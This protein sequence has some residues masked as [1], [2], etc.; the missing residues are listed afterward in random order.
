MGGPIA[1]VKA[2][3]QMAEYNP[4][5]LI[6]MCMYMYGYFDEQRVDICFVYM[7]ICMCLCRYVTED[8]C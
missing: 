5:A 7:H 4:I 8:R 3:A 2:G 6:G 1:V